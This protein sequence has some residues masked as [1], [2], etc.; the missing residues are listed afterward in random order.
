MDH[1]FAIRGLRLTSSVRCMRQAAICATA[2]TAGH[3]AATHAPNASGRGVQIC[4]GTF[5]LTFVG[6]SL[7][8]WLQESVRLSRF[9]KSSTMRRKIV[10]ISYFFTIAAILTVFGVL[11]IPYIVRE[12]ADFVSRLQAENIWCVLHAASSPAA[13]CIPKGLASHLQAL[14]TTGRHL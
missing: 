4:M 9:V 8:V 3:R 5:I 10:V 2:C 7:T 1:T 13:A 14:C 6:R 12:G 11:T